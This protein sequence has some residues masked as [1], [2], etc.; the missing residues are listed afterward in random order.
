MVS[1]MPKYR[2]KSVLDITVEDLN[3]INAKAVALDIDNTI[4]NDGRTNVIDGLT[5]WLETI[6]NAGI[7][8]MI[9]NNL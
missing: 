2:F 1:P 5:E 7:K 4:C 8:A 3:K 9:I 6:Q